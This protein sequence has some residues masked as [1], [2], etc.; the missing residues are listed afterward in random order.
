M[1]SLRSSLLFLSLIRLVEEMGVFPG[2]G[3]WINQN[4]QQPPKDE[5]KRSENVES[6]SVSEKDTNN[7]PA[8]EK[9][10]YYKKVHEKQQDQLWHDAEKKHP[11]YNPPPKVTV[12]TKKGL[13]HMNVE[14]IVGLTPD[15]VYELFTNPETGAFFDKDKWRGLMTNKS[16]K[17]LMEDGPRQV[18]KVKK[19]VAWDLLWFSI[20]IPIILIVDENRKDLTTKYKK[21]KIMFMKVF[22]GNYKVEPIYVDSERLCGQ[23]L[24][25]SR[26]EY[27]RCSGGQGKIA[28]KVTLNQYF[29]PYP[30]FNLPPVSWYIRGIT[31]KTTKNLL[32]SVQKVAT[33]I[34][35]A[36]RLNE[37]G[38]EI[39]QQT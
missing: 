31:I 37:L 25:K 27:K 8:K 17:V 15:G 19:S 3:G 26:E 2:F 6:K 14:L 38:E 21:E 10:A 13:C 34:R 18:M 23:R 9:K 33:S 36:K 30:L 29:Q 16:I 4:T 22:E 24:P 7:A 35:R 28:S 11:W 20:P 1:E 32:L 39:K 12:T 5:P